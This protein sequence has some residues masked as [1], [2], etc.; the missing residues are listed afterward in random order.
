MPTISEEETYAAE[1]NTLSD[2]SLWRLSFW[3]INASVISTA[4]SDT[5][6]SHE[7]AR[8]DIS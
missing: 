2:D 8:A 7:A 4:Y 6:H 3:E 1:N 5:E